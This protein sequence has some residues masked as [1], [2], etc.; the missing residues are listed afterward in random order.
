MIGVATAASLW[1]R[2]FVVLFFLSLVVFAINLAF[3]ELR[4]SS[5]FGLGYGWA[6]VTLLLA[7]FAFGGR[8]RFLGLATRLGLG[9]SSAWL[10]LH[11]WGGLLFCL[12]VLLHSGFRLPVGGLTT[13]VW[14]LSLWVVA[15]GLFGL[16]LQRW[17]P[18]ALSSGLSVEVLWERIPELVEQLGSRA[19]KA[20]ESCDATLLHFYR[21]K[22]QPAFAGPQARW[23]YYVDITG[24][25]RVRLREFEYLRRS[26]DSAQRAALDELEDCY[27]TKLEIDAHYT[28]QAALRLWLLL[29]TP[30]SI[31][32]VVM[33]ATHVV[34]ATIY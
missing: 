4:A 5:V 18:R 24:G 25:I 30:A 22:I 13:T 33:V 3:F 9:S 20:V 8:R 34:V 1:R 17:I 27:R 15:S 10:Q 31:A 12:M 29:H 26:I 19:A 14:I 28:L 2:I 21:R 7:L 32:L 6:A 23:I 11:L 16:G